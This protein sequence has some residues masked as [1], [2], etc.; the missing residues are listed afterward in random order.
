MGLCLFIFQLCKSQPWVN[1]RWRGWRELWSDKFKHWQLHFFFKQPTPNISYN[2]GHFSSTTTSK[3]RSQSR[4][5][6]VRRDSGSRIPCLLEGDPKLDSVD[7]CSRSWKSAFRFW[8]GPEWKKSQKTDQYQWSQNGWLGNGS[9]GSGLL[10]N[11]QLLKAP[12]ANPRTYIYRY[13][14]IDPTDGS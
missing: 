13:Y 3:T 5:V 10:K 14:N 6:S 1:W 4:C 9:S 12:P 11:L 7:S 8:V 2:Q